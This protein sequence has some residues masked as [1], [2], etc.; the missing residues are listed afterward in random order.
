MT[1]TIGNKQEGDGSYEQT[2]EKPGP[3]GYSKHAKRATNT[4]NVSSHLIAAQTEKCGSLDDQT[5][6]E[7]MKWLELT[8]NFFSRPIKRTGEGEVTLDSKRQNLVLVKKNQIHW[9]KTQ[10]NP[11]QYPAPKKVRRRNLR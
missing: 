7:G 2:R 1:M 11:I 8:S 4:E 9:N 6:E 5:N 10:L 3:C